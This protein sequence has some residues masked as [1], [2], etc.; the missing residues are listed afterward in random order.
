MKKPLLLISLFLILL[1]VLSEQGLKRSDDPEVLHY[2]AMKNLESQALEW[3]D[4]ALKEK[5]PVKKDLY[6]RLTENYKTLILL[7]EEKYQAEKTEQPFQYEKFNRHISQHKNLITEAID[8]YGIGAPQLPK[9]VRPRKKPE[10]QAIPTPAPEKSYTTESGF[11]VKF[12][13]ED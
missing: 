11:E 7:R 12:R 3:E 2:V 8:S 1:P 4:I 13:L 6:S 9:E 10:A 5:D